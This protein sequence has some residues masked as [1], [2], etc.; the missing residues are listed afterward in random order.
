MA[1]QAR[2]LRR[3]AE[4]QARKAAR[5]QQL[6]QQTPQT[7]PVEEPTVADAATENTEPTTGQTEREPISAARLAAN[8]EN[9]QH[10][11]GAKSAET[12]AISAQNHTIHGL[13]RHDDAN[14]KILTSEDPE[15]FAALHK[16][17]DEEHVPTSETE[18]ILIRRMA[19]F[20]MAIPSRPNASKTSSST[21]IPALPKTKNSSTYIG[22]T[23]L[24]TIVPFTSACKT[25]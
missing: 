8:R 11:T 20:R 9:A 1:S 25:F 10:S 24:P 6:H 19:E 5:K 16:K 4:R 2:L 22:A 18:I 12:R 15:A 17:L 21:S 13:A 23:K 14:F 3:A 7:T